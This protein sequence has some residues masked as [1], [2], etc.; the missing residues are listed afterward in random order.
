M[1]RPIKVKGSMTGRFPN[2]LHLG[3]HE[4]IV[5]ILTPIAS[6]TLE[7][8][9]MD[10][11]EDYETKVQTLVDYNTASTSYAETPKLL[12]LDS[13]RNRYLS[14]LFAMMDNALTS[15]DPDTL[16]S[17][18]A[19]SAKIAAYKGIQALPFDAKTA[20]IHGLLLDLNKTILEEHLA[21]LY[22]D[23]L[24]TP[25]KKANDEYEKL[26]DKKRSIKTSRKNTPKTKTIRQEVDDM[27]NDICDLL[28]AVQVVGDEAD[29]FN[30]ET[31]VK[32]INGVI[33]QYRQTYNQMQAQKEDSEESEKEEE[34]GNTESEPITP[35]KGEQAPAEQ[36]A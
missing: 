29:R 6:L 13:E 21:T 23:A 11:K 7:P 14:L 34:S 28:V 18:R 27:F 22:M 24:V 12:E 3:F 19:V 31:L 25:L 15:K 26:R 32:G 8:K 4:S 16:E 9:W 20:K 30:A 5:K 1:N 33:D 2:S 17:A 10:I 36:K 35:E